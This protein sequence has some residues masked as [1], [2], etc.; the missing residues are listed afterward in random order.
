M[1][2]E[3]EREFL[4]RRFHFINIDDIKSAIDLHA[5]CIY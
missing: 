1:E 3:R 5:G 4:R 2:T